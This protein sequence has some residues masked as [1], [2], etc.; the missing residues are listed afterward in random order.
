MV[1]WDHRSA[2][3]CIFVILPVIIAVVIVKMSGSSED[4][5]SNGTGTTNGNDDSTKPGLIV[6]DLGKI[7]SLTKVIV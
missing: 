5:S 1:F 6:F 4:H 7:V 3:I 2:K